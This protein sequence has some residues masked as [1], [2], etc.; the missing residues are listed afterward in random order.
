MLRSIGAVLG[1]FVA[2]AIVVMIGTMAATAAFV[3]G[4][5][6]TMRNGASGGT[7]PPR[8]LVAN[9]S[10]SLVAAIAGG[11]VTTRIAGTARWPH[12][13]VL[14]VFVAV[15]SVVSAR[16]SAGTATGQPAWYGRAIA[17]IGIG[18]VLIGGLIGAR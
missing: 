2:M 11:I 18:G 8:Y 13:I 4:G 15:M 5:I 6:Q 7:V 16:Q 10:V 17:A 9:L 12:A 1:G 14:A 3:P